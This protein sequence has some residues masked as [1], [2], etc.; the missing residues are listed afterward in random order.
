MVNEIASTPAL[1]LGTAQLGMAYGIANQAG[2]PTTQIANAL[3]ARALALG[4]TTFDTARAYGLSENRLGEA[5]AGHDH[6]TI[7]TKL[8]PLETLAPS[9]PRGTAAHAVIASI[10]ESRDALKRSHLDTVLLHRAAHLRSH[11]GAI[12]DT[13]LALKADRQ[14]GKLGVS[15]QTPDELREALS[16]RAVTHIQFPLNFLDWRWREEDLRDALAER[17]DV[18]IHVRSA[19]LQGLLAANN[20]SLWPGNAGVNP[21]RFVPALQ[22]LAETLGREDVADLAF[23]YVRAQ[24]FVDGVVVGAETLAQIE[25]NAALFARTPLDEDECLFVERF[26]PELPETLLNPALWQHPQAA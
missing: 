21:A 14:I 13:L 8:A 19:L 24:G 20:P 23:A 1:V 16:L 11:G 6:V 15:V 7:I 5:L 4:I 18:T 25:A 22:A 3:V 12:F 10:N 17:R 2:A 26:L 9:A